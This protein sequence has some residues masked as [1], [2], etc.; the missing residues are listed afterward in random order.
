MEN[1]ELENNGSEMNTK[2]QE[3]IAAESSSTEEFAGIIAKA[4]EVQA[5]T[6]A[7]FD[8]SEDAVDEETTDESVKIIASEQTVE[9]IGDANQNDDTLP[10]DSVVENSNSVEAIGENI[11]VAEVTLNEE[12]TEEEHH[13]LIME[14]VAKHVEEI[15]EP[16]E[17]YDA[18]SKAELLE[19]FTALMVSE[20]AIGNKIKAFAMRDAFNKITSQARNEALA[21]FI[22][23]GG[24]KDDFEKTKEADEE[25]FYALFEKYKS[26]RNDQLASAEKQKI[27]NLAAKQ[28]ILNSLKSLIQHEDNMQK[29]YTEFNELQN[30]WRSVG[31]VPP[32]NVRDLQMNYK[33]YVDRFYDFVKINR[34]L[35]ALDQKKNLLLKIHFCE[36]AEQLMLEPSINRAVGQINNLMFEWREVGPIARDKKDELWERF[37]GAVDKVFDRRREHEESQKGT[38]EENIKLKLELIARLEPLVN[39][40]YEKHN[41]WQDALKEVTAINEEY[42]KVGHAGRKENEEAWIKFKALCDTFFKN[43]NDHY[44]AR[45]KDNAANIQLK[46]ELCIAAEGLKESTDWK[47]TS[48]ELVRLQDEWKKVGHIFDKINQKLWVR[49]KAA[50]DE[51]FTRKSNHFSVIDG[52]QET[53]FAA[54]IALIEQAEIF[55]MTADNQSNLDQLREFQRKWTET[56][57]VP[58]KKKDEVHQRFRVAMDKLYDSLKMDEREKSKARFTGEDNRNSGAGRR[59]IRNDNRNDNRNDRGH[60]AA[61]P[62]PENNALTSKISELANEVTVW[63][64]NIGFFSKSKNADVIRKEFEDKINTAKSEIDALKQKLKALKETE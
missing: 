22:E 25:K 38:H 5:E 21:K 28:E 14:Q 23:E 39:A 36:R 56:G 34:E 47:T 50:C 12:T 30:K 59:D 6:A 43:K 8:L 57:L 2:V 13:D 1:Q 62:R 45:K 29:A 18:M 52:E 3:V 7:N 54:K 41:Q 49:F 24:N 64:N 48:Q 33:L 44:Q 32:A 37:K 15:A 31:S 20:D 17:N 42:K 60:P 16:L 11:P 35:Q 40:V 26:K 58:I 19:K 10:M 9:A 46:T 55:E 27:D 63:Q 61:K 53:N 4:S 51:F